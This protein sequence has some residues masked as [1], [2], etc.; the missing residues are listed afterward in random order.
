MLHSR[1]LRY[2]DE[3]ARLG[4][5]R[6]AAERLNVSA[7]SINR[8]ILVLEE[9][10]GTPIF[11]RLPKT[12][13][14]TAAGELLIAHVRETLKEHSRL[15]ARIE[16]LRGIKSG[17][18]TVATVHG[19]AGGVLAPIIAR[20]RRSH[21]RV[22]ITVLARSVEGVVQALHSGEAD[23]GLAYALPPDPQLS[24]GA[25]YRTRLGAVVAPDHPF[26]RRGAVRLNECLEYPV[27]LA[28]PSLTINKLI[29][30]AFKRAGVSF[31]P[32]Y[33]SNSVE[34]MKA[35]A[36]SQGAVT[37]LSRIDVIEDLREMSLVYVPISGGHLRANEL[38]LARR[39]KAD[40]SP[41]VALL[42]EDIRSTIRLIETE[43]LDKTSSSLGR[44]HGL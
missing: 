11:H 29:T 14:L 37:F 35:M 17:T 31:T 41:A 42:E 26:A 32:D 20:F 8:Q 12:L 40:V 7:S 22:L 6:K 15:E 30:D 38:S 36:R 19:I 34:L 23:L 25:A 43:E 27:V 3:V 21:P 10:M 16:Q 5:I 18:I 2:I 33:M 1:L 44:V 4:S 28:D 39:H 9:E 13:R 24:V